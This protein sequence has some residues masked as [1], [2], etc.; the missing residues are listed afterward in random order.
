MTDDDFN[1]ELKKA[2]W[3]DNSLPPEPFKPVEPKGEP[4]TSFSGPYRFL[5]NFWM[6]NIE[7]LN[8][9]FTSVEAAYQAAK[10][11]D[12][13][14]YHEK[15]SRLGPSEAKK[16]G[17]GIE[18][19]T[20][21]WDLITKFQVMRSLVEQKFTNAFDLRCM[22]LA[23]KERHL[24]EGN[25]WKDTIWGTDKSKP[26]HPLVAEIVGT[27]F[28]GKNALGEILMDTRRLLK[29]SLTG[30]AFVK[31]KVKGIPIDGYE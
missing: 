20:P 31:N 7:A 4:I 25:H 11:V 17:K 19:T 10:R 22:L 28:E 8:R 3:R 12:D 16:M 18:I 26:L 13:L 2:I 5:S 24:E 6:C 14:N 27:V 21:D 9:K 23:T 30:Q 15:L 29:I 1:K